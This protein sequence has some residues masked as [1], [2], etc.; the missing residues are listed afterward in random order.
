MAGVE[1][2]SQPRYSAEAWQALAMSVVS[3]GLFPLRCTRIRTHCE[4]SEQRWR[5]LRTAENESVEQI[6]YTK[7]SKRVSGPAGNLINQ[8]LKRDL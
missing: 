2:A 3:A 8:E 6:Y 7:R 1:I 4:I 5:E